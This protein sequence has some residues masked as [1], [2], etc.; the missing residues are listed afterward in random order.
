MQGNKTKRVAIITGGSQGIGACIAE[1][2]ARSGYSTI[3]CS[4]TKPDVD[5]EAENIRLAGFDCEGIVLDVADPD[6]VR[7]AI[8]AI[9]EK[10][11]RLDVLV[12][13]AGIYGPIGPL[14]ENDAKLW[15]QAVRINICGTAFCTRAAIPIMK[16]GGC[17][18]IIC[19]AGAGAGGNSIKPNISSYVASKFGICGFTEAMSN[20]LKGTGI[21]INAISPGA[22]NTRLL[23][24]V[25]SAGEKAGKDF[26]QASIK[27]KETGG[28]P[29]KLAADLALYLASDEASHISGKVLS[30]V[31]E[32]KEALCAMKDKLGGPLYTLRRIDDVM[33]QE[34]KKGG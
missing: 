21:R 29:P 33:Y 24:Q 4:R 9:A 11:G 16:K 34:K 19:F 15:E 5:R 2:F 8:S 14:E 23:S 30:A 1:A 32:K 31:W 3:I 17:G 13:C 7:T 12:N 25:L 27:Q 26:L 18:C 22:V 20:E 10:Y 28:T 6:A